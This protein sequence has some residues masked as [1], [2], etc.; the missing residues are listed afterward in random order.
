MKQHKRA[1]LY[2]VLAAILFSGT[3]AH[4]TYQKAIFPGSSSEMI[5]IGQASW[6]SRQSPGIRKTTANMEVFDDTQLTCAMWNVPFNQRLRI[7]NMEN[8]RSVEVRVNDRG[9]HKRLVRKGRVIDLSKAAFKKIAS[10]KTGL[11]TVKIEFLS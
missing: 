2:G 7:T 6:Y 9:P 4:A 8:G 3:L 5:Q 11:I 10:L 1:Y